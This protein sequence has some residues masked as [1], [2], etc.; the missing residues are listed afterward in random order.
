MNRYFAQVIS[1]T[2]QA[3]APLG[4]ILEIARFQHFGDMPEME[5]SFVHVIVGAGTLALR[6]NTVIILDAAAAKRL[7]R[8]RKRDADRA[9]ASW[10]GPART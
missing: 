8:L 10:Q 3:E 2:G 7:R 1:Q 6:A 5:I 4:A 9:S